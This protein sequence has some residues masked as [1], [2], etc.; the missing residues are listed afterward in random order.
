MKLSFKRLLINTALLVGSLL[1]CLLLFEAG[2][3]MF[4]DGPGNYANATDESLFWQADSLLGWRMQPKASGEF[5]RPEFRAAVQTNSLG[6]RDDEMPLQKPEGEI[7]ILLLGDSVVAGFEVARPATLEARLESLLNAQHDGRRY[8][9]INAGFRGYGTDQELLFLQTRGFALQPDVVVLA[10][11]PANDLEN[12]VTAHTAGRV[13]G[14][15]YF[16]YAADSSLVLRGVPV[17]EYAPAQ[18]VSSPVLPQS[19]EPDRHHNPGLPA[20]IKKFFSKNFYTYA[21]MAKRLKRLPPWLVTPLHRMGIL[22]RTVPGEYVNFYHKP[23]PETWRK[24]WRLTLDLLLEIKRRC[25][26]R[27]VPLLV[28]MFPL[29]EQVYDRDR[30]IF[31]A[32]YGLNANAYDF[33]LPEKILQDFCAVND[34]AFISPLQDFRKAASRGERLHFITDNHFNSAGHALMAKLLLPQVR[35]LVQIATSRYAGN[36]LNAEPTVN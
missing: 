15:P 34:I 36:A 13:F 33:S 31:L 4:G 11:V 9:V 28:W 16:V 17:P 12:N 8:Q 10:F 3:R 32:G 7:R 23:V 14:K 35:R 6:L 19:P 24:R 22:Q 18:Q 2:L 27:A 29:K 20:G 21:F 26:E 25:D 30:Q 5:I 1:M